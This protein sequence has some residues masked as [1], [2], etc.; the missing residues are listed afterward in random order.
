MDQEQELEQEQ[1]EWNLVDTS[2][3]VVVLHPRCTQI[4]NLLPLPF[5]CCVCMAGMATA[6]PPRALETRSR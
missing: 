6:C 1:A 5:F 3:A 2:F 4:L